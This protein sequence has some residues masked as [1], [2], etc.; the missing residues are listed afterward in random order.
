MT[1]DPMNVHS[2]RVVPAALATVLLFAPTH[3]VRAE[4]AP[5]RLDHVAVPTAQSVDLTCDPERPD[6]H[7][8]VRITLDVKQVTDVLRFHARALTIDSATLEGR[9]G[10]V[11]ASAIEPL[12]PEQ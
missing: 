4:Q 5:P 9:G 10:V 8:T 6:Y 2:R 1:G 12:E 3:T 7:G 11:K